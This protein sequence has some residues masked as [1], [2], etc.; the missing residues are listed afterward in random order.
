MNIQLSKELFTGDY[1]VLLSDFLNPAIDD[2]IFFIFDF[3]SDADFKLLDQWINTHQKNV[4]DGWKMIIR[5]SFS[6]CSKKRID[7]DLKVVPECDDTQ[8]NIVSICD[9][10]KIINQPKKIFVE[11][12]RNDRVFLLSILDDNL[13]EKILKLEENNRL[14]FVHGGGIS[15]LNEQIKQKYSE[16]PYI[17]LMGYAFFDSDAPK[18]GEFGDNAQAL[19]DTLDNFDIKYYCLSRRSIENYL[20][21]EIM[22]DFL[23]QDQDLQDL[24]TI[25]F[26]LDDSQRNYYHM[27]KGLS[28]TS[29]RD[30]GLYNNLD[31]KQKGTL[32]KGFG[33][34][35]APIF[36]INDSEL[37]KLNA[38]IKKNNNCAEFKPMAKEL[39]ERYR[40]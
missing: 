32:L 29:C 39:K 1:D 34:K 17:S 19:I 20:T 30:S 23:D 35:L 15:E 10:K 3:D 16:L 9:A 25:F 7:S 5:E 36:T 21:K 26:E 4:G 22:T 18:P 12:S 2:H 37:K 13:R 31:K 28:N 24:M 40:A 33:S 14:E 27:K 8:D 38:Y 11:N 6:K